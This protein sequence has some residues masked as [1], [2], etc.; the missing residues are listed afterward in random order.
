MINLII[1]EESINHGDGKLLNKIRYELSDKFT[2]EGNGEWLK[3]KQLNHKDFG[4]L[5]AIL[6]ED[7]KLFVLIHTF[8]TN[9]NIKIS[10]TEME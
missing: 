7:L 5:I 3:F 8:G 9:F 10:K 6:A 2:F 1:E 4:K